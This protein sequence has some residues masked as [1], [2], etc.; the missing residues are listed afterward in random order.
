M[1]S[2]VLESVIGGGLSQSMTDC[3]SDYLWKRYTFGGYGLRLVKRRGYRTSLSWSCLQMLST[4]VVGTETLPW[5][6]GCRART[7]RK[8]HGIKVVW[9]AFIEFT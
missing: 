4:Q 7:C 6:T 5:N 1:C 9:A 2:Y 8:T 3:I